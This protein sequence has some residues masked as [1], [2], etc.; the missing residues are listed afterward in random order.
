MSSKEAEEGYLHLLLKAA[1]SDMLEKDDGDDNKGHLDLLLKAMEFDML[2]KEARDASNGDQDSKLNFLTVRIV[3]DLVNRKVSEYEATLANA[4]HISHLCFQ[5]PKRLRSTSTRSRKRKF[6]MLDD[7][8]SN[9]DQN[10]KPHFLTVG[11]R[12]EE[13]VSLS[14]AFHM[15]RVLNPCFQVP[16]RP[17]RLDLQSQHFLPR[18]TTTNLLN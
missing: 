3:E 16:K 2:E 13:E 15:S 11:T 5:V 10:S 18:P 14:N 8:A 6:D 12:E 4:T 7:K 1:E 9:G 17:R